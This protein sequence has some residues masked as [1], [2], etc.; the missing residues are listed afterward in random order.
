VDITDGK[1]LEAS[2]RTP[3]GQSLKLKKIKKR[4]CR[5]GPV[6]WKNKQKKKKRRKEE[7]KKREVSIVGWFAIQKEG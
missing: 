1:R 3:A 6:R 5:P 7:E 2:S 4:A